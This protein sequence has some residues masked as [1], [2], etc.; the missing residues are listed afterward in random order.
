M[1][2]PRLGGADGV[3]GALGESKADKALELVMQSHTQTNPAWEPDSLHFFRIVKEQPK[4]QNL[5][6]NALMQRTPQ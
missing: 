4:Q 5:L 1:R 6:R 3:I 2:V